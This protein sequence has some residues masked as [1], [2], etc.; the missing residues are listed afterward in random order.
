MENP[1]APVPRDEPSD[2]AESGSGGTPL[3]PF[4]PAGDGVKDVHMEADD[5]GLK[6]GTLTAIGKLFGNLQADAF[7][8]ADLIK[9]Y[10][11]TVFEV[12]KNEMRPGDQPALPGVS[13]LE[14]ASAHIDFVVGVNE[15]IAMD[16]D[17]Q[18]AIKAARVV[19]DLMKAREDELVELAREVGPDGA[20]AYRKLLKVIGDADD[21]KVTWAAPGR[22]AVTVSSI[23]AAKAHRTL[24]REGDSETDDFKVVGHLSMADDHLNRFVL[25]L[26][27][28]A[29]RPPQVKYKQIIRGS[30]DESV[31][32]LVKERNLWGKEVEA[33]I[34][35]ERERAEKAVTPRE[36]K[37]TL[38]SV[39]A[40]TKSPS[41]EQGR[42]PM[43]GSAALDEGIDVDVFGGSE[44]GS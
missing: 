19:S 6:V 14:I 4:K 29:P 39:K 36:P 8:L 20:K 10:A 17:S 25:R 32:D 11:V 12:A 18:P 27:K 22:P 43:P 40:A 41:S 5:Q 13:G 30:F 16:E 26:E 28:N 37:F 35:L 2:D 23:E 24:S 44:Q 33:D 7:A 31:G 9:S 21:A 15:A 1:P 38:M 34:H 3:P 42:A